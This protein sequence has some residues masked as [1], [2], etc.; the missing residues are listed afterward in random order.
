MELHKDFN[1]D[2]LIVEYPVGVKYPQRALKAKT[3]IQKIRTGGR[4]FFKTS[5]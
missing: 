2:I 5:S 4:Q 1:A 3:K